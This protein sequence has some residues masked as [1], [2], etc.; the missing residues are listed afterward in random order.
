MTHRAPVLALLALLPGC[1]FASVTQ[2]T[3]VPP[4]ERVAAIRPGASTRADVLA[5]LGPPAETGSPT[6]L[7]RLR[8]FDPNTTRVLEERELFGR[9]R[10]TWDRE[11]LDQFRVEGWVFF[12]YVDTDIALERVSVTFDEAGVVTGVADTRTMGAGGMR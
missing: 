10:W 11:V 8:A 9:R 12:R 7:A 4:R 6:P 2:G 3:G 5:L 1:V